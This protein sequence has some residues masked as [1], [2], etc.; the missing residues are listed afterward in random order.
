MIQVALYLEKTMNAFSTYSMG[1][2]HYHAGKLWTLWKA[3]IPQAGPAEI[4]G[5]SKKALTVRQKTDAS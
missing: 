1:S 4:K 3:E 5:Y 2:R